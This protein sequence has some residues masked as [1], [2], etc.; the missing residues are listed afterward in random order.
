MHLIHWITQA[1]SNTKF[2]FWNLNRSII[3]QVISIVRI[4]YMT[5]QKN[6]ENSKLEW[7]ASIQ[8][9]GIQN[10]V[11]TKTGLLTK[12][13]PWKVNRSSLDNKITIEQL[14]G[15]S[16]WSKTSGNSSRLLAEIRTHKIGKRAKINLICIVHTFHNTFLCYYNA[17]GTYI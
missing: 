16:A 10:W 14:R 12:R 11:P 8:K 7:E 17:S 5:L 1:R 6:W 4:Y 2:S 15:G 9:Y 3:C 13:G